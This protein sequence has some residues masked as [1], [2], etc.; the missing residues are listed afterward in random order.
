MA[1]DLSTLG[2]YTWAELKKAA[3][4]AMIS[5]AIGGG[6]LTIKDRTIGRITQ[7]QAESLYNFAA[8]QE[9]SELAGVTGDGIVLVTL[10]RT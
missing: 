5:A 2:D 7:Q 1:F 9:Q 4:S 3:K 6:T 8:D 10:G